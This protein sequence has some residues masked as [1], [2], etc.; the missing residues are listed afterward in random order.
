M[1][2]VNKNRYADLFKEERGTEDFGGTGKVTK[3][4][5]PLRG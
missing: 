1:K 5:L 2:Q 4:M 3:H